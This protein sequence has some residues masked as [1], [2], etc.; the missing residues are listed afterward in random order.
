MWF[1]GSSTSESS[2]ANRTRRTT[3]HS[4]EGASGGV[5]DLIIT[6]DEGQRF[7]VRS[8]KLAGADR[9]STE[10]LQITRLI[11]AFIVVTKNRLLTLFYV[12]GACDSC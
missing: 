6:T 8:I 5:V 1:R 7:K 2:T 9:A 4:K 10:L 11:P 12:S 3:F